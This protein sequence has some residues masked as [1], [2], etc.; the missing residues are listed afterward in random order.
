M[1]LS[2]ASTYQEYCALWKHY[3]S[4]IWK[5]FAV[6]TGFF[7]AV[8]ILVSWSH[9]FGEL[10]APYVGTGAIL[11]AI[12]AFAY[13]FVL[14][15]HRDHQD[16]ISLLLSFIEGHHGITPPTHR[17]ARI[18]PPTLFRSWRGHGIAGTGFTGFLRRVLPAVWHRSAFYVAA[19]A[20]YLLDALLLCFGL[21]TL[22]GT[23]AWPGLAAVV[24]ASAWI[25]VVSMGPRSRTESASAPYRIDVCGTPSDIPDVA[26]NRQGSVLAFPLSTHVEV[27]LTVHLVES[28]ATTVRVEFD[29]QAQPALVDAAHEAMEH[30][31]DYFHIR[32]K[33]DHRPSFELRVD[34][35]LQPGA[36]LGSSAAVLVAMIRCCA[37]L[38]RYDMRADELAIVA[39]WLER[40]LLQHY[41]GWQDHVVSSHATAGITTVSNDDVAFTTCRALRGLLR[42]CDMR[43]VG[44]FPR[45]EPSGRI[46]SRV[47]NR[48]Q[49]RHIADR[50]D[51][52]AELA[53]NSRVDLSNGRDPYA[54]F[55]RMIELQQ[56]FYR[57]VGASTPEVNNFVARA[58]ALGV[59][60]KLCGAGGGG[61]VAVFAR[62]PLDQALEEGLRQLAP[63]A[64]LTPI[65]A[66][67]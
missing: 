8:G 39:H 57:S 9:Q 44:P 64:E 61:Y 51:K 22:T 34:H 23:W 52:L 40:D 5:V 33:K 17:R 58:A 53:R 28:V 42:A 12:I 25:A 47:A 66:L 46:L 11:L 14:I 15:K 29:G 13:G 4:E 3:D 27:S 63:S 37:K 38:A 2:I 50:L 35:Q 36:G 43:L 48:L 24:L 32:D 7:G 59:Q 1:G 54:A 30:L 21:Y 18:L 60:A 56:E 45:T 65:D 10:S 67:A 49:V 19:L 31:L 62:Q 26:N 16:K 20:F 55:G 41:C 6:Q